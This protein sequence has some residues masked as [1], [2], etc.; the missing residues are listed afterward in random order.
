MIENANLEVRE[1][2][3]TGNAMNLP[4]EENSFDLVI[5][6]NA[7]HNLERNDWIKALPEIERVSVGNSFDMVDSGAPNSK[8]KH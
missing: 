6:I 5:S 2:L 4:F 1:F 7:K 3:V 8:E